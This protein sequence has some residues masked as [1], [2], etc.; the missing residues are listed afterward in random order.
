MEQRYRNSKNLDPMFFWR[1]V[2]S[3]YSDRLPCVLIKGNPS[4]EVIDWMKRVKRPVNWIVEDGGEI[5]GMKNV[6]YR[7]RNRYSDRDWLKS[8]STTDYY[9]FDDENKDYWLPVA[10]CGVKII[11]D[12]KELSELEPEVLTTLDRIDNWERAKNLLT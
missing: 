10:L 1:F 4:P 3:K 5:P 2:M 7:E 11:F 12:A 6:L 8:L 9:I